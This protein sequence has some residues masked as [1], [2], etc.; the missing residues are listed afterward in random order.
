VHFPEQAAGSSGGLPSSAESVVISVLD[1]SGAYS[2]VSSARLENTCTSSPSTRLVP[3]TIVN[4][5]AGGGIV[6][7]VID[8]IRPGPVIVEA[9]AYLDPDGQ[10][11]ALARAQTYTAVRSGE[12]TPVALTL[13]GI[14]AEVLASPS[15]LSVELGDVAAILAEAR[16][17]TGATI[18]GAQLTYTSRDPL[19]ATVDP[20]GVV[21]GQKVGSTQVIVEHP[22][23]GKRATVDVLV[24]DD[25]LPAAVSVVANIATRAADP[26]APASGSGPDGVIESVTVAAVDP[27]D[28][29]DTA[30]AS[31]RIDRADGSSAPVPLQANPAGNAL[32]LGPASG[33]PSTSAFNTLVLD[34]PVRITDGRTGTVVE[35]GRFEL[36]FEVLRFGRVV[37][38]QVVRAT[39]PTRGAPTNNSITVEGLSPSP[40]DSVKAVIVDSD[41]GRTISRPHAA[42]SLGQA[43]IIDALGRVTAEILS[44]PSSRVELWAAQTDSG[45]NGI[46]D[47]LESPGF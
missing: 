15:S 31:A 8:G 47:L 25:G 4:R 44:G 43:V 36:R 32:T 10:G 23:S 11:A 46:P 34:G 26:S 33:V 12:R 29:V 9:V 19:V 37:C 41:G 30:G 14:V 28:T 20:S 5:P 21:Y 39:I 6:K 45:A 24:T 27:S 40:P 38:P 3:D 42:D 7:A 16:D 35:I 17:A 18:I 2:A 13:Q 22:D 1:P